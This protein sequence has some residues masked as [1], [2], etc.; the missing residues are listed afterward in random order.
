MAEISKIQPFGSTTQYDI[1]AD[2][3]DGYHAYE[4]EGTRSYGTWEKTSTTGIAWFP[5][6]AVTDSE[7]GSVIFIIKAYAHSSIIFT[8]TKGYST[9]DGWGINILGGGGSYNDSYATIQ[10]VRIT[11]DGIVELG[12]NA[13]ATHVMINIRVLS[14]AIGK[15][16]YESLIEDTSNPAL[17]QSYTGLAVTNMGIE[18]KRF[19]GK[20]EGNATTATK[21]SHTPDNTTTFLRGDNTWSNQLTGTL[22]IINDTQN[23][24][25]DALLYVQHRSN[26]DWNVILDSAGYNYGLYVKTA[27][28]A[29]NAIKTE[30]QVTASQ[31]NGTLNGNASSASRLNITSTDNAIAR[32]DGTN[33]T[34]QDSTVTIDDNGSMHVTTGDGIYFTG[35][36]NLIAAFKLTSVSSTKDNIDMGWEWSSISGAGAAF[37]SSASNGQFIFFARTKNSEGTAVYTQ[38][39]GTPE[40]SL[41]WGGQEIIRTGNGDSR[42]LRLSGGTMT[43]SLTLNAVSGN[44]PALTFTRDGNLTDW[45]IFVTGGKLSFRSATDASTWTERAYFKDNSGDF[46]ANSFTGNLIGDVTGNASTATKL[47][48]TP[49]NTTTFLRGDNTWGNILTG[50]LNINTTSNYN[51]YK[52][53]VGGDKQSSIHDYKIV[54]LTG[55]GQNSSYRRTVIALCQVSTTANTGFNSYSN[56]YLSFHRTNGLYG[57]IQLHLTIENQYSGANKFNY[58]VYGNKPINTALTITSGYGFRPCTFLYNS[59]LYGGILFDW[60]DAETSQFGF[61]GFGNFIPFAIDYYSTYNGGSVLNQEIY[62]SINFNNADPKFNELCTT[63][64]KGSFSGNATSASRLNISSTDN[65]IARFDGTDGTI[66]DSAVRIRDNGFITVGGI[67]NGVSITNGGTW[68]GMSYGNIEAE[69]GLGNIRGTYDIGLFKN[70]SYIDQIDKDRLNFTNWYKNASNPYAVRPSALVLGQD[71]LYYY[72]NNTTKIFNK[73]EQITEMQQYTILHSGNYNSYSPTLTGGGASG[74]WGIN[75]TGSANTLAY[76]NQLTTQEAIDG[77]L[78][79][80]KFKVATF[81]TTDAN[82]INMASN[83]GMIISLPWSN[84]TYG[85]Q[86]ALDDSTTGSMKFRGKSTNWGDW[87]TIIHDG[88]YTSY[89]VTKTGSGASG[90]WGISITGNAATATKL[91]T[92]RDLWGNSFDG[93]AAIDGSIAMGSGKAIK[94][95]AT[96]GDTTTSTPTAL[97]YGRLQAYGTL[98][99]NANTDNSGTEYVIL[100]A[101][102]GM[103]SNGADGLEVGSSTLKYLGT[104]IVR[105]S[106][107]WNISINGTAS[108]A[109]NFNN[110]PPSR[111]KTIQTNSKGLS[112][113][114]WYRILDCT[115]YSESF[116]ITFY[117]G[118]N[119][120]PPT[121]VTFLISHSYNE[122]TISQIGRSSYIGWITKLRAIHYDTYKFYID[123]YF[124]RTQGSNGV[125]FEITPLDPNARNNITLV[126]YT[127]ITDEL[128]PN[129]ECSTSKTIIA[130][131]TTGNAAT[132]T[133]LAT[134]RN[135]ALTGAVTGNVNFDGSGNISITTTT[136]HSHSSKDLTDIAFTWSSSYSDGD[137]MLIHNGETG[138]NGGQLFRAI[139]KTNTAKWIQ[140]GASGTWSISVTGSSGSCTG[141]A[142][143]ATTATNATNIYS[144]AST[145]KAY[146][147]G[148]T[149]ASSANHG[150]VYNAS[151]YT[152][153]TVLYGA[154]WNDYAEKRQVEADEMRP[155]M[156]VREIGDDT[157]QPTT[158]RLQR[159]CKI[160]SDTYGFCIGETNTAKTPIAVSGRVLAYIYEGREAAKHHIGYG[161]CSGPNGTV[162]IM[163]E[164]EE[165]MYPMQCIGTIS[166][167]PDYETWG[168]NNINVDG[169]VWIYVR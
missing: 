20:L 24:N 156:C 77:F 12:L 106:G 59:K 92:A 11:Q 97:T 39:V 158:E 53:Y 75:I 35:A 14:S 76:A 48:N 98:C 63:T 160:I 85:A 31:F 25:T 80:S 68:Y 127:L 96:T 164:E 138:T 167:V 43:G 27:N 132:A 46:V 93:S 154:A 91:A 136:N 121:P 84:T 113:A 99:I 28:N 89:T 115:T 151:V 36:N 38:L 95:T 103:S 10:G 6:Y 122:T 143:T 147:L 8:A 166:A 139:N 29:N 50:N 65:A 33:G 129:A 111:Y 15:K 55:Q 152:E 66:Q 34:I 137:W 73:D 112:E 153:G 44:S 4:L 101:G 13:S 117:G 42:Y 131:E 149:T 67:N 78:E 144:S 74:T 58:F 159:G 133:K 145:S 72:L 61:A 169:R 124:A 126:D 19:V 9:N 49:N 64:F 81:K 52:L 161:V 100:T 107:T 94:F 71:N 130:D 128:T 7:D 47:S 51:D 141:N 90:S 83:D 86:I 102:K 5:I 18:S 17:A 119:Y 3:L 54:N 148:T 168:E 45:Q 163:T 110:L 150:T 82:N 157:M 109:S 21:L 79:A 41:T 104:E 37:R 135:I 114:G 146:V 162:S 116:L 108:N 140:S 40:G 87:R 32:F 105:N 69:S 30:G 70:C 26:N 118:Y 165:R 123:V 1:N 62:D 142:N 23:D 60:E 16:P 125:N 22:K 88:N 56:G 134:A 120:Q 155:G 2:K 57:M